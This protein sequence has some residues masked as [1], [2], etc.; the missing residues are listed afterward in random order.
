[1]RVRGWMAPAALLALALAAGTATRWV[2]TGERSPGG[3]ETYEG[4]ALLFGTDGQRYL[5]QAR[6]VAEGRWPRG[7]D[8]LR[9][10]GEGAEWPWPTP[11]AAVAT[12]TVSRATGWRLEQVGGHLQMVLWVLTAGALW[13]AARTM[14][15]TP[16]GAAASVAVLAAWPVWVGRTERWRLDTDAW[17]PGAI[18]LAGVLAWRAASAPAPAR[19]AGW[20]AAAAVAWAVFAWWWD[21]APEWT[22]A[23][24]AGTVVLAGALAWGPGR[25]EALAATALVAAVAG[26]AAWTWPG[27]IAQGAAR[28]LD[29]AVHGVPE[30]ADGWDTVENPVAELQHAEHWGWWA[31]LLPLG[32]LARG[33]LRAAI[34]IGAFPV[35]VALSASWL[36]HR[37]MMFWGPVAGIAV[38]ALSLGG[39]R[40]NLA[41]GWTAVA[42]AALC[43]AMDTALDRAWLH[44]HDHDHEH[45][46]EEA[47]R[48]DVLRAVETLTNPDAVI[49]G[50]NW[51][52]SALLMLHTGRATAVDE[53][54]PTRWRTAVAGAMEKAQT[55]AQAWYA[56]R[57]LASRGTRGVLAAGAGA[58]AG[59]EELEEA[60]RRLGDPHGEGARALAEA[61]G[62]C[63][64]PAECAAWL[65]PD[66]GRP[67]VLL[68][69]EGG[70]GSGTTVGDRLA[71]PGYRSVWLQPLWRK[72]ATSLW[73]L[74]AEPPRG[75]TVGHEEG[76]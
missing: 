12:G 13:A 69:H 75:S 25:G 43:V 33:N 59:P 68:A 32:L 31:L 19:R 55:D 35:A 45:V 49:V 38:G 10:I 28:A 46:L 50:S 62:P 20:L 6:E 30:E 57:L 56:A 24:G 23:I 26:A 14:G 17:I 61:D 4:Q 3:A 42:V 74:P 65:T 37:G 40:G 21:Q 8:P 41:A 7:T 63:G 47:S 54:M 16:V 15:L 58:P 22:V 48:A 11:L 72:G 5:R 66:P 2:P 27:E 44:D 34:A 18:L 29:V 64:T 52:A 39:P 73:A 71:E 53:V 36:G 70:D 51:G 1:M 60:M 67:I 9:R 76:G